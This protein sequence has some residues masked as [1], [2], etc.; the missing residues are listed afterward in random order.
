MRVQIATS[1]LAFRWCAEGFKNNAEQIRLRNRSSD[2]SSKRRALTSDRNATAISIFHGL[3]C[4]VCGH[5][6]RLC[7]TSRAVCCRRT[8]EEQTRLA[9]QAVV[10]E[11]QRKRYDQ[12]SAFVSLRRDSLRFRA[13]KRRAGG[14]GS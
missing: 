6:P 14:E 5:F 1:Q 11:A 9:F 3:C 2:T 13:S 8:H 4:A 12:K 10:F 7:S